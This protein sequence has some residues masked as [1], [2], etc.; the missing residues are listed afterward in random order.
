MLM[1]KILM[2][3]T[4]TKHEYYFYLKLIFMVRIKVLKCFLEIA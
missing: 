1:G 4:V 2:F 3:F